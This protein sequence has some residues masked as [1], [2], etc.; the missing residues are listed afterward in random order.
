M[1]PHIKLA[2]SGSAPLSPL[3]S[4]PDPVSHFLVSGELSK[5]GS[6]WTFSRSNLKV[7]SDPEV[8]PRF[9]SLAQ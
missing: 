7:H 6:E 2:A 4:E 1:P 3:E 8:S 5:L 9:L